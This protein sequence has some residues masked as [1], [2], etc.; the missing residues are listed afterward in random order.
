MDIKWEKLREEN[1]KAGYRK[2]IKRTYKLPNGNTSDYD[3]V[4][5]GKAVCVLALT[6]DNKVI[7]VKIYRPGPDKVLTELPGGFLDEGYTPEEAIKKEL[8]EETGYSGK[9][10]LLGTTYE[11]A[12]STMFRYHFIAQDCEKTKE[13]TPEDD[14]GGIE[15]SLMTIEEFKKHLKTGDLTDPETGYM[16]LV[17]LGL[18]G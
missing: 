4:D 17:E 13:P 2:I 5:N 7:T 8:L 14:E 16:G 10:K 11:D 1:Y 3:V 18:L 6:T 12:Y 9:F 15:T